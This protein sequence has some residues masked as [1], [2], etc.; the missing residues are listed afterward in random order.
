MAIPPKP[1]A[2]TVVQPQ[3]EA[4]VQPSVHESLLAQYAAD[5][6][7]TEPVPGGSF[8]KTRGGVIKVGDEEVLDNKLQIVVVHHVKEHQYYEGDF[9]EDNPSSPV[10]FAF[11]DAEGTMFAHP[12][13]T[14]P[15]NPMEYEDGITRSPCDSCP[16]ARWGSGNGRG[17]ACREVRRLATIA[18]A[19]L[20][21][22]NV[23]TAEVL[24]LKVPTMSLKGWG[25]YVKALA[26]LKRP[27]FSMVTE[28]GAV[29][30][31]KS[32]F[33]ITFKPVSGVPDEIIEPL[34]AL[35]ERVKE[36]IGFPYQPSVEA[37]ASTEEAPANPKLRGQQAKRK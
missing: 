8:I 23:A 6:S 25:T 13:S 30:D 2:M 3:T 14:K 26:E 7:A 1:K 15:Q 29:P 21:E 4:L 19:G 20:D 17:K 18:A 35:H 16:Q 34:A 36:E 24:Y 32:N 9:D 11:A 27:P 31:S 12:L 37:E 33:R 10:C 22:T 5:I 28:L